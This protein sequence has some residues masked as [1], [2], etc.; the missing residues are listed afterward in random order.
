[1]AEEAAKH[2]ATKQWKAI[3][4]LPGSTLP[5]SKIA[6]PMLPY[7]AGDIALAEAR[8][9]LKK[10]KRRKAPGPDNVPMEALKELGDVNLSK[11]VLMVLLDWEKAFDKVTRESLWNAMDR[12]NVH[13]KLIKAVQSI[14]RVT[15]FKVEME[16]EEALGR[17]SACQPDTPLCGGI[18]ELVVE[19]LS[20]TPKAGAERAAKVEDLNMELEDAA[21]ETAAERLAQA[22]AQRPS[23]AL[24]ARA[25]SEAGCSSTAASN[26]FFWRPALCFRSADVAA[27]TSGVVWFGADGVVRPMGV[28]GLCVVALGCLAHAACR[29]W[30][31][32]LRLERAA[33][34]ARECDPQEQEWKRLRLVE[35]REASS[36][37]QTTAAKAISS[38]QFFLEAQTP[39][40][41]SWDGLSELGA[42]AAAACDS[43]SEGAA[44][45]P[46]T[47]RM[48]LGLSRE[49]AQVRWGAA[50]A[51]DA[52]HGSPC[53]FR[54]AV[55]ADHGSPG[56]WS[57]A[58]RAADADLGRPGFR[59]ASLSAPALGPADASLRLLCSEPADGAERKTLPKRGGRE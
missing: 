16:G 26:F 2:L 44:R 3:D 31:R 14:Y 22:V 29:C 13:P 24:A 37:P 46:E 20:E 58:C 39:K 57:T 19:R 34:A 43:P 7:N 47:N 8:A 18:L 56:S 4:A 21:S 38:E 41:G 36:S 27:G 5:R 49:A 23:Q 33:A 25:S 48:E 35:L 52:D 30:V 9:V 42:L 54:T 51:A 10:C 59:T 1:M 32:R 11:M 53:S 55:D 40:S 6:Q 17:N 50:R 28:V 15:Q 45:V 12:M